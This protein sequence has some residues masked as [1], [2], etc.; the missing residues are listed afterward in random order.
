MIAALKRDSEFFME[1]GLKYSISGAFSSGILLFG[2]D[3][4]TTDI[5]SDG[6]ELCLNFRCATSQNLVGIEI[7]LVSFHGGKSPRRK[8]KIR[9]SRAKEIYLEEGPEREC[10]PARTTGGCEEAQYF[11]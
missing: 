1:A 8:V 2:Y 6:D 3:W 9:R 11:N 4:P 5:G 7:L 10:N